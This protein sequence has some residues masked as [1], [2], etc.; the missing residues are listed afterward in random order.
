VK[1]TINASHYF[2]K[3]CQYLALFFAF[4]LFSNHSL[5]EDYTLK[6]ISKDE[7]LYS[8]NTLA[9]YAL[10]DLELS[11]GTGDIYL[12]DF[13]EEYLDGRDLVFNVFEGIIIHI[14]KKPFVV[15]NTG[16][17]IFNHDQ[18]VLN[19]LKNHNQTPLFLIPYGQG[20]GGAVGDAQKY[21]FLADLIEKS[22]GSEKA[23]RYALFISPSLSQATYAHENE[24]IAQKEANSS[25]TRYL[26]EVKVHVTV[27]KDFNRFQRFGNEF[28]AYLVHRAHLEESAT[29]QTF[30][31]LTTTTDTAYITQAVPFV[32]YFAEAKIQIQLSIKFH[33]NGLNKYIDAITENKKF[34]DLKQILYKYFDNQY[35]PIAETLPALDKLNCK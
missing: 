33:A 27:T 14:T 7:L 31:Y 3:L 30:G 5:A 18:N 24:H 17:S 26:Q 1:E 32:D 25:M 4:V 13:P 2:V 12:L 23:P 9:K 35:Y 21:K 15:N 19:L 20:V 10:E 28:G 34:C 11:G 22:S 8:S 29:K 16:R 6:K